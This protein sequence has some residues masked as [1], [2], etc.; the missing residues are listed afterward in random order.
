MRKAIA[1]SVLLLAGLFGFGIGIAPSAS[2]SLC[3]QTLTHN[4]TLHADLDCSGSNTSGLIVGANGLTINLNGF[5]LT[6]PGG[7]ACY[8]FGIDDSDGYNGVTLRDGTIKNYNYDVRFEYT[9][10]SRILNIHAIADGSQSYYPIAFWYSQK[11]LIAHSSGSNGYIGLY[12][13]ENKGVD[14][15]RSAGTGSYFGIYDYY[16]LSTLNHDKAIGNKYGFYLE[17]TSRGYR[18]LNSHAHDNSDTGFYVSD[19]Y[20][21]NLYQT[22]LIGNRASNNGSYGFYADSQSRGGPNHAH[23][24]PTNCYHVRCS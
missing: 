8:C 17:E 5:T 24:N 15:R 10:G 2:A 20:P 22:T 3:G 18:V 21:S 4:V 14:V 16:S 23:S 1:I 19:N 9:T 6:G 11:G 12:L 13:Y 7:A